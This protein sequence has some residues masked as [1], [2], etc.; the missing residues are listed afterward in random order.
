MTVCKIAVSFILI[1]N[2]QV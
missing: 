2:S 1:D